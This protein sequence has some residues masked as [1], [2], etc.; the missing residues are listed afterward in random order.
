V[1]KLVDIQKRKFDR[2]QDR[3]RNGRSTTFQVISYEQEIAESE[4]ML[5][6]LLSEQRKIES[7]TRNFI[8]GNI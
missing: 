6:K 3:L 4:V 5:F 1:Q 2:E 7:T 8:E